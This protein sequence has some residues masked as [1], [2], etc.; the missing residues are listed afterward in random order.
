MHARLAIALDNRAAEQS[1]V[2]EHKKSLVLLKEDLDTTKS[3][4]DQQLAAMTEHVITLNRKIE[5]QQNEVEEARKLSTAGK[6]KVA[7]RK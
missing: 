6:G 2:Q 4:Y 1:K 7:G 3:N 5:E